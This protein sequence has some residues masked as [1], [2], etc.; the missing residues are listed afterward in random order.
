MLIAR[1]ETERGLAPLI[2]ISGDSVRGL[3]VFHVSSHDESRAL[4]AA[5]IPAI[6]SPWSVD[7]PG[8][9][10]V[11]LATEYLGGTDD[12]AR[13]EGGRTHVRAR[14]ET[15][16]ARGRLPLRIAGTNYTDYTPATTTVQVLFPLEVDLTPYVIGPPLANGQGAPLE[17]TTYSIAV[18]VFKPV[19]Y[20]YDHRDF[21]IVTQSVNEQAVTLPPAWPGQQPI[22]FPPGSLR[23]RS[24]HAVPGPESTEIIYEFVPGVIIN[25]SNPD[26]KFRWRLEDSEGRGTTTVFVSTIY[27][28]RVWPELL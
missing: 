1:L 21:A 12:P 19:T 25:N 15:L 4:G 22:T 3:K 23:W 13:L 18:H 8:L 24:Q 10:C 7:R 6:L 2:E 5:G 9:V 28:S 26:H 11:G 27:P 16:T 14:F 20:Q 17:V